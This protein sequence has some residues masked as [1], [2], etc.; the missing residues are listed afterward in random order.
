M[1]E[2]GVD[3]SHEELSAYGEERVLTRGNIAEILVKK[4]YAK[5]VKEAMNLYMRRGKVGYAKRVL[6]EPEECI[7]LLHGAGALVFVAHLHQIDGSDPEKCIRI[8]RAL[9]DMGADGLETRY[10]EFDDKW[11]EI[12]EQIAEETGCLRSGGSDFHGSLKKNLELGTGYG[13]L[14]VPEYFL[15]EMEK[16]LAH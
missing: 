11:R 12:T 13:D 7:Q 10:C 5:D 6:P 8:C 9:I 3:I 2:A 15:E 4:G 16:Y 14:H 1:I